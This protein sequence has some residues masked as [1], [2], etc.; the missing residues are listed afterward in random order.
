MSGQKIELVRDTLSQLIEL[1]SEKDRLC[2]VQF[3]DKVQRLTPL[4]CVTG[5]KK[6]KLFD[7]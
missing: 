4:S 3:D 6:A 2:I 1:L 5:E 7:P